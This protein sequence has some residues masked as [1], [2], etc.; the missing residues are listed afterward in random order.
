MNEGADTA[1]YR[2]IIQ[3][4]LY[5][6]V[7]RRLHIYPLMDFDDSI[8]HISVIYYIEKLHIAYNLG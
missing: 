8:S 2:L 7:Y 5:I 3:P 6:R 4:F 1:W